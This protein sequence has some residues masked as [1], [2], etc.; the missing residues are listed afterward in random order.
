M[1]CPKC[2]GRARVTKTEKLKIVDTIR[3][4]LRCHDCDFV[5]YHWYGPKPGVAWRSDFYLYA[6]RVSTPYQ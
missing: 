4:H 2:G 6:H 1:E 5:G 3:R